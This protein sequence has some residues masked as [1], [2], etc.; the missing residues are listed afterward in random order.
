MSYLTRLGL[1]TRFLRRGISENE[2][3]LSLFDGNVKFGRAAS[4]EQN[5]ITLAWTP[6]YWK[7]S[8]AENKEV[9]NLIVSKLK[10]GELT[11]REA[12]QIGFVGVEMG[13]IYVIS[14]FVGKRKFFG[15][16][17]DEDHFYDERNIH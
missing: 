15:Y 5:S 16:H 14:G 12:L 17:F 11:V 3:K 6:G 13:V 10:S 4:E 2:K 1:A 8:A 7:K 9:N